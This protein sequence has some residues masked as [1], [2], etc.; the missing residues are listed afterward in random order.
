ML[1]VSAFMDLNRENWKS[2]SKTL[3]HYIVSFFYLASRIQYPMI[4]FLESKVV[5]RIPKLPNHIKFYDI[6]L[7]DSFLKKYAAREKEIIESASFRQLIPDRRKDLPETNYANYN[8]INHSKI[9]F[10]AKAKEFDPFHSHYCWI[11][12]GMIRNSL[13]FPNIPNKLDFSKIPNDKI[14]YNVLYDLPK[15]E[16]S[17]LELLD[18]DYIFFHGCQFIIPHS[19]VEYYEKIYECELLYYHYCGL[20]DDD[21]SLTYK[22]YHKYPN[23]FHTTK[24]HDP[25]LFFVFFSN[26][27]NTENFTV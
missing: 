16:M 10:V 13:F 27:L 4:V 1:F 19:L 7:V 21:Q 8:L 17:M 11:D 22:I 6:T 14:F 9:N 12:F 15:N 18:F 26:Y 25:E 3:D 5:E 2:N 20:V 24:I 23:L